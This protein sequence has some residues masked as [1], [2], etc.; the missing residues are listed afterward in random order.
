MTEWKEDMPEEMT[1]ELDSIF[2]SEEEVAQKEAIFNK[3]NKEY[4]EQQQR[5][6]NERLSVEAATK[7]QEKEDT[8]QA[9]GHARY[10][11]RNRNRKRGRNRSG[12]DGAADGDAAEGEPTTE[13]QLLAAVSSRRISR[14]INYDALSSIFDDDGSFST[15]VVDDGAVANDDS[16]FAMI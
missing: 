9:E 3:M 14:K 8:A 7:D 13:E 6:E 2:R 15:D 12:G 5:K 16:M 4:L 10:T 11:N 1:T